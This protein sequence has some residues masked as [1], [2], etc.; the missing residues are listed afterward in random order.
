MT[1]AQ[2]KAARNLL[3]WSAEELATKIGVSPTTIRNFELGRVNKPQNLVL[4]A[5][6]GSFTKAGV[7]FGE[8]NPGRTMAFARATRIELE[9]GSFV[10]LERG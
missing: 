5:L 9:D 6:R 7:V 8:A 4:E 3:E 10:S 2:C 1:P